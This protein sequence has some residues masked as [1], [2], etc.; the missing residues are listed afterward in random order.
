MFKQ[1]GTLSRV[2]NSIYA[3]EHALPTKPMLEHTVPRFFCVAGIRLWVM[4]L[5]GRTGR[6][7]LL[8]LIKTCRWIVV[9][10]L[11]IRILLM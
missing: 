6:G 4:F 8:E 11:W 7:W 1:M 2:S 9:P 10:L 3:L 5:L